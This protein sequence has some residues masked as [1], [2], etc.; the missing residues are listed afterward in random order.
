[1]GVIR[2]EWCQTHMFRFRMKTSNENQYMKVALKQAKIAQKIGD[3]PF[4]AVIVCDDKIIGK[5]K[6][7]NITRFDV[8]AH[9]EILALRKACK[10]L[11]R[12][13]L[14]DCTI[15]CTN[16]PC[17]MCA[18][19]L[20]QAK[21][22]NVVVGLTRNDLPGFL[23]PRKILMKDLAKDSCYKITIKNSILKEEI[24]KLFNDIK[25]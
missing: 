21:I 17:P 22:P 12:N 5:G 9:P 11:K 1:V 18:A 10:K 6:C 8:T 25:K 20:F 15:Y 19:A 3:L 14:N 2:T 23:R 4:G 24:L 16:E 13:E 7:E